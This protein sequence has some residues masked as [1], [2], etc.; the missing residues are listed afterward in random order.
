MSFLTVLRWLKAPLGPSKTW[1]LLSTSIKN[2]V[3]QV[4][5]SKTPL[6]TTLEVSE[7]TWKCFRGLRR[8]HFWG[9]LATLMGVPVSQIRFFPDLGGVPTISC[10]RIPSREAFEWYLEPLLVVSKCFFTFFGVAFLEFFER[11]SVV[12]ALCTSDTH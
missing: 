10:F 3:F 1:I 12:V 9:P 8:T 5:A 7:S 6:G 4:S 2:Q 11:A